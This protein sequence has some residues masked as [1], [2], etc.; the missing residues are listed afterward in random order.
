MKFHNRLHTTYRARRAV[1][2][3]TE[4]ELMEFAGQIAEFKD[5]KK[6]KMANL[7]CVLR[8]M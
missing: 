5:E 2:P 3:P 6:H 1:D 7:T 8:Y 4:K